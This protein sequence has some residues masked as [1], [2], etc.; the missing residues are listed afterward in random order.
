MMKTTFGCIVKEV[1]VNIDRNN[2]PY[3]YYVAGDHMD[4]EDFRIHRR[5]SF[6]TDDVGPAFTRLFKPG[7]ILYGSRRT[8]L[9]K[10]CVADFEGICSNTTFVLES[11]DPSVLCQ[12]FLPFLMLSDGFSSFS[13]KH[14][15]GSTNPYILFSDLAKYE[16]DLPPLNE[17][18]KLA[19][20]L[21]A[22]IDLKEAY[23]RAIVAS[24]EMAK[25]R[26]I[27]MFSMSSKRPLTDVATVNMGQS[28]DSSTYNTNG[29]GMPFCQGK[30]EFGEKYVAPTVHCTAPIKIAQEGDI[31]VSVRAPVGSVNI[32]KEKCCIGRGLAAICA[33][34][35][36]LHQEFLFYA[37][38]AMENEIAVM[39]TGST[40]KA[41]NKEQL[42]SIAVP[43]T[44]FAKQNT[45]VSFIQQLDKSKFFCEI[46]QILI[47]TE[48]NREVGAIDNLTYRQ[49]N[50]CDTLKASK[51]L[52]AMRDMKLL[53]D[54]GK[55]SA[56][57]YKPGEKMIDAMQEYENTLVHGTNNQEQGLN[58]HGNSLNT[59]DNRLNPH[60]RGSATYYSTGDCMLNAMQQRYHGEN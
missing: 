50:N 59:H 24:D 54:H 3:L 16:F 8:Y 25:S 26:F 41:I 55:G 1:K 14:S 27:E 51:E 38:R 18:E 5:G 17:Q 4:S 22:A 6:A 33:C 40:F 15:K 32:T 35:S 58:T 7:Q 31:L 52:R 11:A 21:W 28:P 45:F 56:T 29:D 46:F 20:L 53:E 57:Y 13:I 43:F 42:L 23:K 10:V 44:D 9:K 12:R 30:S 60:G 19:D 36:L 48:S 49:M 39:G 34:N 2:N 47:A 37:L